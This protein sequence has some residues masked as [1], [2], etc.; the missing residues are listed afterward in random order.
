MIHLLLSL[1]LL[2]PSLPFP[3]FRF[4]LRLFPPS[5]CQVTTQDPLS[6]QL[7]GLDQGKSLYVT[8][9]PKA[10]MRTGGLT[11]AQDS[12]HKASPD[13]PVPGVAL[14]FSSRESGSLGRAC[15][16]LPETPSHS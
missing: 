13:L 1:L 12:W 16:G 15:W 10:E 8:A 11:L 7:L 2:L 5:S 9:F 14:K 6:A 4:T 3:T